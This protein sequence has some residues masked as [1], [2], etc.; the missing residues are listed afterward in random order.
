MSDAVRILHFADIHIGMENYGKTDP[1]TGLSSRVLDFFARLYEMRDYAAEHEVDLAIFAGDAFKT[2]SPNPTYQREFA[3]FVRE[4]ATLCPV[5]LLVGNHDL[6]A[7]A[8]KA[9]SIEIYDTLDV[10]NVTVGVD[11][12]LH[13]IE[14]RR[15]PVQ[16]A[17]APYPIRARLLPERKT[18]GLTIE[19][20]DAALQQ[21]IENRLAELA[22][23][24]D[25]DP[26]PRVLAGH[27]SVGGALFGSERAVMLGRDAA[28]SLRALADPRWDYVALGHI[29]K[30]QCL[31]LGQ[32]DAPP[33]IYS[34]S[35]ERIDFGEEGD[36]KGFCWVDLQRGGAD[37]RFVEVDA[38]PFVTIRADAR[39]SRDPTAEVLRAAERLA[40]DNAIVRV[41]VRLSESN[42]HLLRDLDIRQALYS[43]GA[44][45]VA[46]LHK[47][48]ERPV[49]ARLGGSPEE[50]LPEELL[51]RYFQ[52]KDVPP[53]RIQTLLDAAQDLF[54]DD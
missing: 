54:G 7:N 53:D 43:A 40:V 16:V 27:F 17:T 44:D 47:D 1:E 26:A 48:I 2:R 24:A 4:L 52:G 8:S 5:V 15:G 45:H 34:G 32:Q 11:Y 10:P 18:R 30:H 51:E 33:V 29:H 3:R 14:T 25:A 9:A 28:V 31:T 41:S 19:E 13:R 38:R 12:A 50:L 35:I 42:A 20:M 36:P 46:A 49:R 39:E 22:E 21:S 6:P 23:Q 37:W